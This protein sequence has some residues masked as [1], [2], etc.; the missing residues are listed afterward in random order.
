MT[1]AFTKV[2]PAQVRAARKSSYTDEEQAAARQIIAR[3]VKAG[4]LSLE[5]AIATREKGSLVSDGHPYQDR[6]AA[7]N[8]ATRVKT[9]ITRTLNGDAV[10]RVA[11][12]ISQYVGADGPVEG[13]F[14]YWLYFAP[15]RATD[16]ADE[17]AA[18]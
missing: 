10:G 15:P 5:D 11:T 6:K 14:G 1:F 2:A 4:P 13:A 16:E 8:A 12:V 3:W 9:L 7:R 17:E 18:Q